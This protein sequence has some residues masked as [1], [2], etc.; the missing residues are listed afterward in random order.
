[1]DCLLGFF[2][3]LRVISFVSFSTFLLPVWPPCFSVAFLMSFCL[4]LVSTTQFFLTFKALPGEVFA[5]PSFCRFNFKELV[6]PFLLNLAFSDEDWFKSNGGWQWNTSGS[7][8][9][10]GLDSRYLV[11]SLV[12]SNFQIFS[13][14]CC[15]ANPNKLKLDKK[16]VWFTQKKIKKS[17]RLH[18]I[19]DVYYYQENKC[20][21]LT[22]LVC[23]VVSCLTTF[24]SS[25]SASFS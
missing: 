19:K 6:G 1:M 13:I 17:S 18:L 25:N 16:N 11:A 14:G 15:L 21:K 4:L 10:L 20:S 22:Y 9:K 8:L 24:G 3:A 12:G 23:L 2:L 7:H 5:L